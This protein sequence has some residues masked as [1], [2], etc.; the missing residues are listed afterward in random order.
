MKSQSPHLDHKFIAQQRHKL[1]DARVKLLSALDRGDSENGLIESA[2][3]TQASESEDQAQDLS[4]AEN[5]LVLGEFIAQ[6][7]AEIDHALAKIDD[8][9]YGFSDVSGQPIARDRLQAY[10]Q[11]SRTMDEEVLHRKQ[12]GRTELVV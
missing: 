4:L 6:Q 7:C 11:A 10:P 2:A 1:V 3:Q 9:T 8:G 5:N 12:S